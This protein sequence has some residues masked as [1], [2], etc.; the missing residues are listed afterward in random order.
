MNLSIHAMRVLNYIHQNGLSDRSVDRFP[1]EVC[2]ALDYDGVYDELR[3]IDLIVDDSRLNGPDPMMINPRK[4]GD[5][6]RLVKR[7]RDAEV[8]WQVLSS[9]SLCPDSAESYDAA[10]GQVVNGVPVTEGEVYAA[11]QRLVDAGRIKATATWDRELLR[12]TLTQS[13]RG[14]LEDEMST[15]Q[16]RTRENLVSN[17]DN[18]F[19]Q[20]VQTGDGSNVALAGH[21][22][23]VTLTVKSQDRPALADQLGQ[24]REALRA[25]EGIS[26]ADAVRD[27][28]TRLTLLEEQVEDGDGHVPASLLDR[29]QGKVVETLADES[30]QRVLPLLS[31]IYVLLGLPPLTA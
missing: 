22:S 27:L 16:I 13:G 25:E 30:A 3:R 20:T 11:A 4:G 24:L 10:I 7:Y 21:R 5:F 2:S 1:D 26:D 17:V 23:N 29:F 12:P 19:T 15:V 8:E 6:R 31:S 28:E 18:S 9:I 14:L